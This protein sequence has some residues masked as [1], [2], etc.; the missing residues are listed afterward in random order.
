ML[1]I[2]RREFIT[3]LGGAAAW[4]LGAR[5]QQ[6]SLPVVGWLSDSS[7]E[8][9]APRLAAFRE[10]LEQAG[11]IERQ[12][13]AIEYRWAGGAYDRL[14]RFAAE[15]VGRRVA[16]I[17]AI[18]GS[19]AAT[20]AKGVTATIPIV[21]ANGS[22]PVASG[23]VSSL[24]QPGENITGVSFYSAALAAK[25]LELLY[26]LV[27]NSTAIGF[28]ANPSN[29]IGLLEIEQTNTAARRLGIALKIFN[30]TTNHEFETY[31][32]GLAGSPPDALLVATNPLLSVQCD[33]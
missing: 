32:S 30:S 11:F 4:P 25:R 9:S 26:E 13:V 16:V 27:P 23:L 14:P 33:R 21:F 29:P 17:A 7:A 2:R 5:A 20:A 22:D 3:L 10:G 31:L 1:S 6:R 18:G 28:F 12:N 24:N 15:L 19:P 8:D